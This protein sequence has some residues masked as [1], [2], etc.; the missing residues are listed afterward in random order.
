MAWVRHL[1]EDSSRFYYYNEATGETTWTEPEGY[2]GEGSSRSGGAGAQS[3]TASQHDASNSNNQAGEEDDDG[4]LWVK[5]IDPSTKKPYYADMKSSRTRWDQPAFYTSDQGEDD[6]DEDET[7]MEEEYAFGAVTAATISSTSDAASAATS[8]TPDFIRYVDATTNVPYYY[9]TKT[10]ETQWDAPPA[11]AVIQDQQTD[12]TATAVTGSAKYQ[13]WLNKVANVPAAKVAAANASNASDPVNRL[14]SILGGS[15]E[16]YRWQQHF[17]AK[18]QRYYYYDTQTG[19]TQ[20]EPPAE[21]AVAAGSADWVPADVNQ[22]DNA[23]GPVTEQNEYT[24]V[25]QMNLLNGRF[26]GSGQAGDMTTNSYFQR[27][28]VPT[29]KAGRQMANFFDL[30]SFEANRAEA[31]RIKEELKT[32]NI[33]WRKYNEEKKRKRHRIRNK[34]MY[35]D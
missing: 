7:N 4:A 35:E 19:T 18:T 25:A 16:T 24:M 30:S 27:Q 34:W 33:N 13:E 32:K 5:Y 9:N 31:K 21:G 1:D 20:W 11:D 2:T 3:G 28:G 8:Q 23:S 15:T 26:A 12:A 6:E 22:G 14:N 29:D 17:D 10:K